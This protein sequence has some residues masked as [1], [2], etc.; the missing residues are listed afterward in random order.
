M[1]ELALWADADT[2]ASVSGFGDI[3]ALAQNCRFRDCQHQSEPGCAVVSAL[4]AGA[5]SAERFEHMRKLERE[6][7][8]QQ[9]R[10][11][12]RLR[13]AKQQQS[14]SRTRAARARMKDKAGP[15]S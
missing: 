7:R 2:E 4:E 3:E 10:V 5:L 9:A 6:M 11:D 1:R 12:A 8:Y 14:K 15:D 13:A